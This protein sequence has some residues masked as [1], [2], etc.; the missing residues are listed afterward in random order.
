MGRWH[1]RPRLSSFSESVNLCS[2]STT[3]KVR[4]T[5]E[6]KMVAGQTPTVLSGSKA[7]QIPQ[8]YF[9]VIHAGLPIVLLSP[10]KLSKIAEKCKLN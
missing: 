3:I 5:L 2:A 4:N 10:K 1:S 8:I 6:L 9:S 7:V